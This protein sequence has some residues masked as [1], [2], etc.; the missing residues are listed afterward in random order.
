MPAPSLLPCCNAP[1]AHM[2]FKG[3]SAPS[4]THPHN[5]ETRHPGAASPQRTQAAQRRGASPASGLPLSPG[6]GAV[7]GRCRARGKDS[8]SDRDAHARGAAAGVVSLR[9]RRGLLFVSFHRARAV[10][11]WLTGG[12]GAAAARLRGYEVR[13]PRRWRRHRA[14]RERGTPKPADAFRSRRPRVRLRR[15]H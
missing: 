6:S 12:G 14:A 9:R 2:V 1:A 5:K 10:S 8:A 13:T 7:P 4:D 15:E 11:G 3:V